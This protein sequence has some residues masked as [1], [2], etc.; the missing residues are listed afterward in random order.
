MNINERVAKINKLAS[1]CQVQKTSTYAKA[2]ALLVSYNKLYR[3]ATSFPARVFSDDEKER[4]IETRMF[5]Q[6]SLELV[7]GVE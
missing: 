4:I 2:C 5:L 3:A 7:R 6:E 1:D